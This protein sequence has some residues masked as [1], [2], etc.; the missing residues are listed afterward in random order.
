MESAEL[1]LIETPS[2]GAGGSLDILGEPL[3]ELVVRVE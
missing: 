2:T 1:M 3:G